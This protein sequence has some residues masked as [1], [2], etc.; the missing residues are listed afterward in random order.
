MQVLGQKKECDL[1]GR[2]GTRQDDPDCCLP[3]LPDASEGR[4]RPFPHC[5]SSEYS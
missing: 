4:E 1:R 5:G 3:P 2:D